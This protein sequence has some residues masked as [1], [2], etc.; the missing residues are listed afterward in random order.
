MEPRRMQCVQLINQIIFYK[1]DNLQKAWRMQ[2]VQ[3]IGQLI[4]QED[5]IQ[6]A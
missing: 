1:K 4:F 6:R 3:L 5:S 2:C